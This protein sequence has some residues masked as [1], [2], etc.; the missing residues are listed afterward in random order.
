MTHF[1]AEMC[2]ISERNSLRREL[3]IKPF[4]SLIQKKKTQ[5][6][7]TELSKGL[8]LSPPPSGNAPNNRALRKKKKGLHKHTFKLP[9][10][11]KFKIKHL[12]H[13]Q[14]QQGVQQYEEMNIWVECKNQ[15]PQ[16]RNEVHQHVEDACLLWEAAWLLQDVTWG[17]TALRHG[18][19][20]APR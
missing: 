11:A 7:L 20:E 13:P 17:Y 5:P 8:T 6:A 15:I 4:C 16:Q 14:L 3:Q 19:H 9:L 12:Q 10:S 1:S 2:P 18:D